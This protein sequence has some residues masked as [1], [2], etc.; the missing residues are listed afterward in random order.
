[1]PIRK[2]TARL[3]ITKLKIP[4]S[5]GDKKFPGI[6]DCIIRDTFS[7]QIL[8][9]GIV[10]NKLNNSGNSNI[11]FASCSISRIRLAGETVYKMGG[12]FISY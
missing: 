4:G 7:E 6:A 3:Y 10:E 8:H 12:I 1:M 5:K 11:S 9:Y 2:K